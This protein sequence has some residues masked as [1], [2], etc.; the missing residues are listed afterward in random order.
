MIR[1]LA[2]LAALA[3]T[4][5]P[6]VVPQPAPSPSAAPASSGTTTLQGADYRVETDT[7][8]WNRNG[9]FETPHHVAFFRPGSD[10]TADS[11]TGNDKRGTVTLRGNVIIHD[12]GNAPEATGSSDQY[13]KGGPAT[14][15]CDQ[16]DV[17]TKK[18]IYVATGHVHFTQG[19]REATAEKGT[20]NRSTGQL[21]LEGDV[22]TRDNEQTLTAQVMDYNTNTKQMDASGK[23]I[24]IKQPVPSPEPGSG[25]PSPKPKKRKLP[26]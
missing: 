20:M 25:S 22:K 15:T 2:V 6:K 16:L 14:L 26:F 4:P 1:T 3:A 21:R 5:A 11:A 19:R 8:I 9:D 13:A 7:V 18:K 17:D 12:N 23:P 10:G 24:I